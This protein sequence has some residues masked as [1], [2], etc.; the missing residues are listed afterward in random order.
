M[1]YISGLFGQDSFQHPFFPTA[2]RSGI[3]ATFRRSR[4]RTFGFPL[5]DGV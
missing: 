4:Y 2:P 5:V 3:E 1:L